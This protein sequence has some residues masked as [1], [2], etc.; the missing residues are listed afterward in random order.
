V[1]ACGVEEHDPCAWL[2]KKGSRPAS[3]ATVVLVDRS[4][5][6]RS[7]D[8]AKTPD[9]AKVLG[10]H[11]EE[12][13]KRGDRVW[14]GTFDG[15][16]ATVRWIADDLRTDPELENPGNKEAAQR[17]AGQCLRDV[18][19]RAGD[20]PPVTAETDVLGSI[21]AGIGVVSGVEG[22]KSVLVATDGLAT[23]EC[24]NLSKAGIGSSAVIDQI[25]ALCTERDQIPKAPPGLSL[26]LAGVG[27][28]ADSAPQPSSTQLNWLRALWTRLCAGTGDKTKCAVSTDPISTVDSGTARVPSA[29][30]LDSTIDFPP[31]DGG[32]ETPSTVEWTLGDTVLFA[33]GSAELAPEGIDALGRIATAISAFPGSRT[34]VHGHTDARDTEQYNQ[35]LS[36]RRAE[37]VERVLRNA[38]ATD[39]E[40]IGHGELAPLCPVQYLA[41]GSPDEGAMQCNRRV[42]I[43]VTKK[44]R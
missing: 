6:T 24:A 27:H 4:N 42:E 18:V 40:A 9:Y 30:V 34:T 44:A 20:V 5:S 26:T 21:S 16:A 25:V 38:G 28:P 14:I 1:A 43:V 31:P 39:V 7:T 41:D 10:S 29:E 11:L 13:A 35:D 12:S 37:A 15:S 23:T 8:S 22:D 2:G 19:R 33:T 36:Q 17:Q 3:S 32:V